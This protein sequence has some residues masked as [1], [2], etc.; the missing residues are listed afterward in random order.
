MASLLR[1]ALRAAARAAA[2]H[3][4]RDELDRL[5]GDATDARLAHL[6]ALGEAMKARGNL[7]ALRLHL[8]DEHNLATWQATSN[9]GYVEVSLAMDGGRITTIPGQGEWRSD[10][11]D[12]ADVARARRA[13]MEGDERG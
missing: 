1:G 9:Y 6:E 7:R 12:A 8:L 10:R 13:L 3:V 4:L 5:D 11:I 2:R